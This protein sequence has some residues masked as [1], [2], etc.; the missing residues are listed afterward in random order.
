MFSFSGHF[1]RGKQSVQANCG[2][3]EFCCSLE[4]DKNHQGSCNRQKISIS[5]LKPYSARIVLSKEVLFLNSK[6]SNAHVLANKIRTSMYV[7]YI[8]SY[9]ITSCY[10]RARKYRVKLTLLNPTESGL[11]NFS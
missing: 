11:D 2:Q 1:D 7:M 8:S 9:K 4:I 3:R 5:F 6:R 10:R